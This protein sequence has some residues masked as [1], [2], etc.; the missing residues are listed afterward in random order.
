MMNR[1]VFD[2]AEKAIAE[3]KLGST[4]TIEKYAEVGEKL[5]NELE[6]KTP[7][8]AKML[9]N[10]VRHRIEKA[11]PYDQFPQIYS[12]KGQGMMQ[13]APAIVFGIIM[14]AFAFVIGY[15]LFAKL[16]TGTNTDTWT[17]DIAASYGESRTSILD[18][19]DMANII[20][21]AVVGIT[22]MSFMMGAL[23]LRK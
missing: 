17:A 15:R 23:Y 18:G 7:V 22:I 11:M 2:A 20:P 16:D 12:R 10:F 13:A 1:R 8:Q 19:L 21:F 5:Y 6:E 9:Y 4:K 14:L 3:I